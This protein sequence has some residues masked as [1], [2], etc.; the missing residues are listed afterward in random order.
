MA[1]ADRAR[2]PHA[3]AVRAP[4]CRC[5][6][7][8]TALRVSGP[9]RAPFE[10]RCRDAAAPPGGRPSRRR[11]LH[12]GDSGDHGKDSASPCHE[13]RAFADRPRSGRVGGRA[14]TSSGRTPGARPRRRCR[15]G[16]VAV[17]A[18]RG[19][20]PVLV[21]ECHRERRWFEPR[22][23]GDCPRVA[24]TGSSG[25]AS[26][27]PA[28]VRLAEERDPPPSDH[29]AQLEVDEGHGAN[30]VG[31]CRSCVMSMKSGR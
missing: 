1:S 25:I 23:V 28:I 13:H 5:S 20:R 27:P 19:A 22:P 29:A 11:R 14:G 26:A 10:S 7:T 12:R 30:R 8:T 31:Q 24:A 21:D 18:N 4:A 9:E 16:G 17:P 2:K 15:S 3:R 6:P